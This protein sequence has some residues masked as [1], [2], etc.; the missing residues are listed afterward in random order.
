MAGV[1]LVS[2]RSWRQLYSSVFR[3]RLQSIILCK[4]FVWPHF[5]VNNLAKLFDDQRSR[6]TLT[7]QDCNV[8]SSTVGSHDHDCRSAKRVVRQLERA[9]RRADPMLRNPTSISVV[10]N[11]SRYKVEHEHAWSSQLVRYVDALMSCSR[12]PTTGAIGPNDLHGFFEA[13]IVADRATTVDAPPA[14]FTTAPS[15][16]SFSHAQFRSVDVGQVISALPD[17]RGDPLTTRQ[18]ATFIR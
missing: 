4:P 14:S 3:A 10:G 7:D 13:N 8:S 18:S 12:P 1:E 2:S 17:N 9:V 6:W 15:G 16:R 5:N 11:V